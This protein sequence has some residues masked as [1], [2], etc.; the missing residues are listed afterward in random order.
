MVKSNTW[1]AGGGMDGGMG[2]WMNGWRD[3]GKEGSRGGG[4]D[5]K[6]DGWVEGLNDGWSEER[7]EGWRERL[8]GQITMVQWSQL[9]YHFGFGPTLLSVLIS[10]W[11]EYMCR[12][13]PHCCF[14]SK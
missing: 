6:I 14:H 12:M 4:M 8:D 2:I 13:L 10:R 1:L 5:G 9:E 11:D 7:R 3:R